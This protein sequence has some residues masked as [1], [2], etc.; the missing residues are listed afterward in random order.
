VAG[1]AASTQ[2]VTAW[3]EGKVMGGE[4]EPINMDFYFRI[5][6]SMLRSHHNRVSDVF[7]LEGMDDIVKVLR[8]AFKRI[9]KPKQK[10]NSNKLYFETPRE[11]AS[12]MSV[13][14]KMMNTVVPDMS[15][16]VFKEM[17]YKRLDEY[18]EHAFS[19]SHRPYWRKK[20][21]FIEKCYRVRA[22]YFIYE[23]KRFIEDFNILDLSKKNAFD[24]GVA[25]GGA[26]QI[27]E[28]FDYFSI[29]RNYLVYHKISQGLIK[30]YS[31][32]EYEL[33]YRNACREAIEIWRKD[34][35]C[36]HVEMV[37]YLLGKTEYAH[38]KR[39]N[40]TKMIVKI[41]QKHQRARGLKG[42]KKIDD[43]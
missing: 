43:E 17:I 21:L 2:R 29:E 31:G 25:Y 15:C 7:L 30:R 9:I 23:I 19:K 26:I 4:K 40:L 35:P 22:A 24:I 37:N 5:A 14:Y 34:D 36:D 6:G 1:F 33:A 32:Y 11:Y 18:R 10:L 41:A 13:I 42:F 39:N 3:W 12:S 27:L 38:L 20:I 8:F 28:H 16:V